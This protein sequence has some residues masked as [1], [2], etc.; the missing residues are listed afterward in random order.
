[1]TTTTAYGRK[2]MAQH[3]TAISMSMNPSGG[4]LGW[5]VRLIDGAWLYLRRLT[6]LFSNRLVFARYCGRQGTG[7]AKARGIAPYHRRPFRC[8]IPDSGGLRCRTRY[9]GDRRA[10]GLD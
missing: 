3:A 6:R 1:M 5:W 2:G 4:V 7:R 9:L 10:A 8:P